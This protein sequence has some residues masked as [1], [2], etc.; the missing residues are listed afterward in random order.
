MRR[1]AKEEGEE[2]RGTPFNLANW[3]G[4]ERPAVSGKE[5]ELLSLHATADTNITRFGEEEEKRE[6][7]RL[8]SHGD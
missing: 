5:Q 6:A 1:V 2:W 8:M 3:P 4:C 7:G